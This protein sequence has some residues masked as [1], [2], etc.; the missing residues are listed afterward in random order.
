VSFASDDDILTGVANAL[1]K[2]VV[3]LLDGSPFWRSIATRANTRAYGTIRR[4]LTMRGFS[5]AQL[6]GWDDGFEFQSDLGTY[7]A[8]AMGGAAGQ[9]EPGLLKQLDRREELA[10]VQVTAAGVWQS[11]ANDLQVTTGSIDTSSDLFPGYV[12]PDDPRIGD[13]DGPRF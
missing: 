1:K 2:D 9:V 7:F 10:L 8:L 5:A 12:D 6:A 11:P 3:L 4:N 13:P